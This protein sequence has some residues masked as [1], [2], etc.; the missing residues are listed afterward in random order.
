MPA[1]YHS[2]IPPVITSENGGSKKR[3]LEAPSLRELRKRMDNGALSHAEV[4]EVAADL[5][6][7]AA[8]VAADY[9][10]NSAF[11][12][13]C[14]CFGRRGLAA[15]VQKLFE[16]CSAPMRL[17]LLERIAPHL[18]SIGCHKNGTWAAQK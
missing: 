1:V 7:D 10:G 2:S 13:S 6:E 15:I 4:D 18:A 17:A 11:A 5:L 14:A 9:I 16:R 8:Q 12:P 3:S